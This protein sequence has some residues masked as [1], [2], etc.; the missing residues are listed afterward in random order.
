MAPA[1]RSSGRAAVITGAM[2]PRSYIA[3]NST[4][5]AAMAAGCDS[6]KVRQ[7]RIN[8]QRAAS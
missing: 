8:S 1:T 5:L 4:R 2:A 3:N 7:R 6:V